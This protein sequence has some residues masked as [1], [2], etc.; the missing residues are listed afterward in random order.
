MVC[1]AQI[2]ALNLGV[3]PT[4]DGLQGK[5]GEELQG[6]RVHKKHWYLLKTTWVGNIG[7][8]NRLG[9]GNTL[10]AVESIGSR[11]RRSG[12]FHDGYYLKSRGSGVG[13]KWMRK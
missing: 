5:V 7:L 13:T 12:A 11:N 8:A 6:I 1:E 9:W 3:K 10:Q 2:R 4:R